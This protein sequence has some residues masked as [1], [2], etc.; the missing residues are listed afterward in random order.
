[1]NETLMHKNIITIAELPSD[2]YSVS[3]L[4]GLISEDMPK[5]K[6]CKILGV[7]QNLIMDVW[8]NHMAIDLWDRAF[9]VLITNQTSAPVATETIPSS[10][11]IHTITQEWETNRIRSNPYSIAYGITAKEADGQWGSLI[12]ATEDNQMINRVRTSIRKD[13]GKIVF[14]EIRATII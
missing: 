9:K 8:K 11:I 12:W 13:S 7:F 14:L 10:G 4:D 3:D 1:M 2:K 6:D 5:I